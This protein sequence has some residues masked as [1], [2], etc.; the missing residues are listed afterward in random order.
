MKILW[1][2][3]KDKKNPLAGGAEIVNEEL[4]KRLVRNGNEVVFI[5]GGF[6]NC[7]SE[8]IIDGYKVIRL[9]NRLSVYFSAYKYYKKNLMGWPD[10]VI[11][12]INSIPFF[13]K[14][15]V[16][17]KNIVFVQQLC[18]EIWFYQVSFPFNLIGYLLEP[19]Y[20]WLLR[21]S[22]LITGSESTKRDLMKYGFRE[23]N[24]KIISEGIE[25]KPVLNLKEIKK[26]DYPTILSLGS[27]R[28]M[29]R[30]G[31]IIAAFEL[32]KR[33]LK[34]LCLIIAGDASNGYG[35]RIIKK[36][37]NSGYQESITYMGKVDLEKKVELLQRSHL[38]IVTSVKEGW[39]LVV[40]EA[41]SQGTPAVA[42]NVD[43]LRD[44][45]RQDYTGIICRENTPKDLAKNI[46]DL[47]NNEEK[48][49]YLRENAWRWSKEINF[50]TSYRNFIEALA[51]F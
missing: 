48:Y 1:F 27:I 25:I 8:E 34:N 6:K 45:V 4:A 29:K 13:C 15:Y 12:E 5:V 51:D 23:G 46:I 36:V 39:G 37:L 32:A 28:S 17:E 3:W 19:I 50:D 2:T 18:R 10:L 11:D 16:K 44:S 9:G 31:H 14:F 40:T 20:L 26:F 42:Y 24:I 7:I 22:K 30:T 33:E 47:L 43:G 49:Q 35:R 41:N 21:N 38:V